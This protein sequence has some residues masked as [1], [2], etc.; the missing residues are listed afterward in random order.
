MIRRLLV[1]FPFTSAALA[2]VPEGIPRQ[3]ARERAADIGDGPIALFSAQR[4]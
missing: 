1:L 2:Q 3:L 4:K